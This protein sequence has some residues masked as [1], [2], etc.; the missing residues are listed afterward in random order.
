MPDW[1]VFRVMNLLRIGVLVGNQ[2]RVRTA[3]ENESVA[4]ESESARLTRPAPSCSRCRPATTGLRHPAT[5]S[6]KP[7]R[8]SRAISDGSVTRLRQP[9]EFR[10]SSLIA[11]GRSAG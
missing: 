3:A 7:D 6:H 9:G 1:S 2:T 4:E 5:W 11:H 8:L 10:L